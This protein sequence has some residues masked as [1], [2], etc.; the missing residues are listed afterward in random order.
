MSCCGSSEV[1]KLKGNRDSEKLFMSLKC[2]GRK[3]KG[4]KGKGRKRKGKGKEPGTW[5]LRGGE[6]GSVSS[7]QC[8]ILVKW[9]EKSTHRVQADQLLSASYIGHLNDA[10]TTPITGKGTG[11]VN[12]KRKRSEWAGGAKAAGEFDPCSQARWYAKQNI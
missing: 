7:V 2:D 12:R 8:R 5:N 6:R 4:K 11:K 1:R 3:G 10:W 9:R